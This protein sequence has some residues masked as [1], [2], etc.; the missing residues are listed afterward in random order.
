MSEQDIRAEMAY[1]DYAVLIAHI[2]GE[3]YFCSQNVDRTLLKNFTRSNNNLTEECVRY[4]GKLQH[5]L[6]QFRKANKITDQTGFA[7]FLFNPACFMAFGDSDNIS[8][9]A[10]DDFEMAARLP[11]VEG[12][13]VRQT[14]LAFCP[15]LDSLGL[16]GDK[17]I[18][19]EIDD[20][21]NGP[22]PKQ[23]ARGEPIVATKH[24]FLRHRPL[25][26]VTYYKLNGMAV[27]G[28]GILMQQAVYK[29]MAKTV[30]EVL[31]ILAKQTE[32]KL[33]RGII[34]QDDVRSFRC[35]F[36][37]PAGWSDVVT[38][39]LC[40]NYS[41][42]ITVLAA[43]RSLTFEKL[44]DTSNDRTLE[45][46]LEE[47]EIHSIMAKAGEQIT[48][49]KIDRL[50]S[51]N[52][53]FCSTFT[54]L[55]ISHEALEK[56]ELEEGKEC[57]YSGVVIADTKLNLCPGHFMDA[58]EAA[59]KKYR[60]SPNPIYN[61][62]WYIV[63]QK[64]FSYQQLV[65]QNYDA[66]KAVKLVDLIEQI[67]SMRD[68]PLCACQ[69]VSVDLRTHI[70]EGC[71]ELRIPMLIA[72]GKKDGSGHVELPKLQAGHLELRA[73]L[74]YVHHKLF[75]AEVKETKDKGDSAKYYKIGVL[76]KSIQKLRIPSPLSTSI[77]YVYTDF[78]RSIGDPFLFDSVV[79]LC[80]IFTAVYRLLTARLPDALGQEQEDYKCRAFL[81][82]KDIHNLVELIELMQSALAHRVQIAFREAA[83][84]NIT[85]DVR[86]IGLERI[87]NAADATLKCGL[88]I[89]RRVMN[90]ET[91]AFTDGDR[92]IVKCCG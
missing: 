70:A 69:E 65:D 19:C 39:M 25:I 55:G 68:S 13:A 52:H 83:R 12:V 5:W 80:D 75:E 77:V 64:D 53:A 88:G 43:L 84:W 11:L 30:K 24:P 15:T 18:F 31:A 3:R 2:D 63:G 35:A 67:K 29:A 16:A 89:L 61:Y 34:S 79:D 28:P 27:L 44:Y 73:I 36:L 47:F 57:Y 87:L 59:G 71:T 78:G 56:D 41:V 92:A 54:S 26:A 20:V 10:T 14:C 74:D 62:E 82:A 7:D 81:S 40:S 17:A 6:E 85:V 23:A 48:G 38:L 33:H 45:N 8:I 72:R 50:L 91:E 9:V 60:A 76:W 42:M 46:S 4:R 32:A 66:D 58:V 1:H 37:D 90:G 21:C 22:P 49:D 86:G 51:K